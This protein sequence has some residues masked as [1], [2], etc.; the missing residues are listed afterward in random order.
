MAPASS[1]TVCTPGNEIRMPQQMAF[2][3]SIGFTTIIWPHPPSS[4]CSSLLRLRKLLK[5]FTR[6][7]FTSR[8]T[9][10]VTHWMP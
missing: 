1:S 7:M 4:P 10:W 9:S 8:R 6:F 5:I 3:T 2:V